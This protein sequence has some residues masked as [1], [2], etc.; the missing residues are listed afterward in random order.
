MYGCSATRISRRLRRVRRKWGDSQYRLAHLAEADHVTAKMI[1][2]VKDRLKLGGVAD[3]FYLQER[4]VDVAAQ[5]TRQPLI[6]QG[7]R[8]SGRT[9]LVHLGRQQRGP[10]WLAV[11]RFVHEHYARAEFQQALDSGY[12]DPDLNP[13][14]QQLFDAEINSRRT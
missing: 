12:F 9:E 11:A 3:F 14:L 8:H 13:G 4:R 1:Q 7:L 10:A 2:P 6:G 5:Q